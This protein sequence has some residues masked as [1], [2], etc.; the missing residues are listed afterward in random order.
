MIA[1]SRGCTFSRTHF[2]MS[3]VEAPGVKTCLTPSV[4]S[5]AESS[6]EA[7]VTQRTRDNLRAAIVTVEA[8][9]RHQNA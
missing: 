8:R 4:L 6:S 9:L 2:T 7:A 3:S 1:Q 5:L